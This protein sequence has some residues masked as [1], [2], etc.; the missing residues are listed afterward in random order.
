MHSIKLIFLSF[1]LTSL[2]F[3]VGY[4]QKPKLS[5]KNKKALGLYEDAL[6][7]YNRRLDAEACEQ[8]RKALEEDE[9]F[10]EARVTLADI[11]TDLGRYEEAEMNFE[12]LISQ[13]ANFYPKAYLRAAICQL[14]QSKYGKARLNLEKFITLPKM[15]PDQKAKAEVML[16]KAIFGEETIKHPVPYNPINLG[17]NVN[18]IHFEYFPS[19]TTD[20]K[21]LIFT[22]NTRDNRGH[23]QEDFYASQKQG[24]GWGL[25]MNVG[26]PLNTDGNEGAQCISPDGQWIFFTACNRVGGEGSC[27]IHISRKNKNGWS[28]PKNPGAPLNS[29]KWE[30]QPGFSVDGKTL[31]FASNRA[32][33]K[34]RMDIW[35]SVFD[36]KTGWGEPKNLEQVNTSGD[37]QSPFI[38]PDDQTFYFSSDGLPGMGKQDLF[39][40]RKK[41]DGTW[42]SPVNIGYPINTE[43]DE[44]SLIVNANGDTAFISTD[45]KGGFGALDIY[46]FA[47]YP[48]ARPQ[49][50]TYFKGKIT[51]KETKLPLEATFELV[52]LAT[53][54]IKARS[55]STPGNGEFLVGLP[56]N[57]NYGLNV[58]KDGY[59]FYSETFELKGSTSAA[60]PVLKNVEMSPIKAGEKIVLRNIFFDTNKFELKPESNSELEKL[61][62]ILSKNP[63]LKVEISGHTDNAGN[64]ANNKTLSE[65]RAKAVIEFLIKKG[66]AAN[67]L[68]PK[69]YGDEKPIDTNDT[70]QGRANNRRTEMQIL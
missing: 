40:C 33:G 15:M 31:Y 28:E 37:E 43:N 14:A 41:P 62:E 22:R 21:T 20:G 39:Y 5:S 53:G 32:G 17:E 12:K 18:T 54:E 49:T 48:E 27:D 56:I 8:F 9:K 66:I 10:L 55:A 51:D 57:R 45:K 70:E 19:I 67:R 46:S 4:G 23:H 26:P 25:A 65:N 29:A 42:G 35:Y 58:S 30:S 60:K 52:D 63:S 7:S 38:H 6:V 13:D 11:L 69:G 36:N 1:C 24:S 44:Q 34:G 16:S 47:L 50:V 59:L 3:Q 68:S 61:N 64:K 2:A